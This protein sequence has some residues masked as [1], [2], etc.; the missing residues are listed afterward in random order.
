MGPELARTRSDREGLAQMARR[1]GGDHADASELGPLF[2]KIPRSVHRVG[3]LHEWEV[4]NHW[5]LFAAFLAVLSVEW[6]LRR[7]RGLA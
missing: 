1:S 5:A 4:W 3:R 7:R 6:F 2:E